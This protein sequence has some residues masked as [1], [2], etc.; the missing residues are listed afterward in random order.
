MSRFMPV[1]FGFRDWLI[2]VDVI[3]AILADSFYI[4]DPG[5]RFAEWLTRWNTHHGYM[6]KTA[7]YGLKTL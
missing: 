7:T 4:I 2:E 3:P 5:H 1:E 6:A